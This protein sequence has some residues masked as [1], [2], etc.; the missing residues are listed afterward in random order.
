MQRVSGQKDP[1]IKLLS[2]LATEDGRRRHGMFFADGEELV[3]RAF[4]YGANVN[5]IIL[6]DKFA[7][8][9]A[10]HEIVSLSCEGVGLFTATEG[11]LSKIVDAK[12][13][14]DCIAIVERKTLPI[15]ELLS[16]DAPVL[17]MV[18]RGENADNLGM[19]LRSADAAG[20]SGVVLCGCVDPFNRRTVRGS[21]GAIYTLDISVYTDVEKC[22]SEAKKTGLPVV[23]T[24]ANATN[25]YTLQDYTGG[26]MFIIGNE[27][28]GI[29]ESVAELSDTTVRI[30][31]LGKINSLNIAAATTVVLY[32]A[33]RQRSVK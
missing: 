31:M 10:A 9:P 11:L 26:C 13:V 14:P 33:V 12:P 16:K 18:E 4:T 15:S 8:T 23:A 6:S 29:S 25:D 24:S 22:M 2:E 27:H 5:T 32:E 1:V 19:I 17:L 20:A 3:K 21:R 28:T 30:P 7:H